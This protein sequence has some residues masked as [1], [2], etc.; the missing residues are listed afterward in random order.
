MQ[1]CS[2]FRNVDLLPAEHGVNPCLESGL[3][4]QLDEKLNSLICDPIFRIIEIDSHVFGSHAFATCRI[5]GEEIAEMQAPTSSVMVFENPPC[6][7]S[8]PRTLVNCLYVGCHIDFHFVQH[9]DL[10]RAKGAAAVSLLYNSLF[11]LLIGRAI[12]SLQR[13]A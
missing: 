2:I 9:G 11:I 13:Q 8:S 12:A 7:G 10:N 4:R 3:L 1:R 6:Q 5:T